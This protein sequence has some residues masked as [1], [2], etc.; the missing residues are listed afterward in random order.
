MSSLFPIYV[1]GSSAGLE[2]DKK[3][4]LFTDQAFQ[5]LYN[6]YA[7]RDRT[8]KREGNQLLD[9][10]RRQLVNQ[11]LGNTDGSG[12]FSGNI[13]SILSLESTSEIE[14]Q[15]SPA[16]SITVGAQ[17]FTESAAGILT[18]DMGGSGTI[19]YVTG[20]LTLTGAAIST[21]VVITFCYF[22]GLPVMGIFQQETTTQ[23]EDNT[24]FFDTVY[25][26]TYNNSLGNYGFT[27]LGTQTWDGSDSD[28]FWAANYRGS[29]ASDR[30]FFVTN[31][32]NS[33]T[34]AMQYLSG[35]SWN[36][37]K[38]QIDAVPNYLLQAKILIPYYGRL[39]ALNTQ[40]GTALGGGSNF[41]NRCRFSQIG[42]PIDSSAWRSDQFGKGGFI[43]A[44]TNESIVSAQFFKNTLLVFFE[45]STW[46]LRYVGE[47]GLP[48]IWERISSDFGSESGNST[49]TF[50]D[51]ILAFGDKAIVAATASNVSRIDAII[52][53][54]VFNVRNQNSG[55]ERISG[56][57]DFQKELVYW[58]I[59][60]SQDDGTTDKFPSEILV[61]N[62]RNRTFATF[63]DNITCL[64]TFQ[65]PIDRVLWSRTDIF[66]NDYE[67]LWAD[68][69]SQAEFPDIVGGNQQGFV[70]YFGYTSIDD[71]SEYIQAI[72]IGATPVQLTVPNHNLIE[73]DIIYI[74]GV[75][76]TT[77]TDLNDQFFYVQIVDN[78]T[79]QLL[80]WDGSIYVN[81]TSAS[82][83]TY[84]GGGKISMRPRMMVVTKD[85]APYQDKG[86]Q[87]KLAYVD[88]LM[89]ATE[90]A[91]MTVEV[92]VN[93]S[94]A[95]QGNF[96]VGQTQVE[97]SLPTPYYVPV[98]NYVWHRFYAPCNG[99][100]ITLVL[101][102]NDDEMNTVATHYQ[103]WQMNA[104][105]LW[106]RPGGKTTF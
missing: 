47:Y 58:T 105:T 17:T 24:I 49:I 101:T 61:Y 50:D 34:V 79:I 75:T 29:A 3:P 52:P 96:L 53:D 9:R 74:T 66:W 10:L 35:S 87:M 1:A 41:F 63:R 91:S 65:N 102:Y 70:M 77:S 100:F 43:D 18:G 25:S 27:Q 56:V 88:F 26:Y 45:K 83:G 86:L 67:V 98:S 40:E 94:P 57:R 106:T 62:Y 103:D 104:F 5:K 15:G 8:K 7:W 38:P 13:F 82:V 4:F 12:N 85:F 48:F 95:V 81:F 16:L 11:N 21:A 73:G 92:M 71:T 33:A 80:T 76:Y 60:N 6:A 42:S 31:N 59:C 14:M 93:N 84:I 19:N 51:F 78:N 90:S 37:F 36:A 72:N 22:P 89:D 99:Q 28:F 64:G 46:Q 54:Y 97:T 32:H 20:D 55:I 44:P 2:Q 23:N 30:L 39:L 69:T 68:P